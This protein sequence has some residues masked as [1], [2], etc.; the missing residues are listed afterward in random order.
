M[1]LEKLTRARI[2]QALNLLGESPGYIGDIGDIRFLIR[3]MGIRTVDQIQEHLERFYP[4]EVLTPR[5]RELIQGLL[6]EGPNGA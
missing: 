5:L 2:V 4:D 1:P 3:K 6:A